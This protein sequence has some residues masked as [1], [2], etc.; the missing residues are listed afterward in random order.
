MVQF[1]LF[2]L[3]LN[4]MKRTLFVMQKNV[5]VTYITNVITS[6]CVRETI[7]NLRGRR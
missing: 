5:L 7:I 3:F 1:E 4:E 6:F 2:P